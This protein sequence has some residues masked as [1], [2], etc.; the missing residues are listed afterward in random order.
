MSN[1]STSRQSD[2]E[3]S[4]SVVPKDDNPGIIVGVIGGIASGKSEV[5]KLLEEKGAAVFPADAVGHRLLGR[6]DIREKIVD[7]FGSSCLGEN[8]VIDRKQLAK[9]FFSGPSDQLTQLEAILH[10]VIRQQA[11]EAIEAFRKD[12]SK[13]MLILDVPLLIEAG[14][15]SLCDRI[16]FVETPLEIRIANAKRRGWSE[17]ELFAREGTQLPLDKK[18]ESATDVVPNFGTVEDLR[19]NL[20]KLPWLAKLPTSAP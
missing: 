1:I 2:S 9:V 5:S 13:P 18:K 10:P 3:P 7:L 19:N 8:G 20:L 15:E 4:L 12:R 11:M 14:W 6:P 17:Q 16:V